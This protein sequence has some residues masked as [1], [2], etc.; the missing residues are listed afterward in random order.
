MPSSF[1]PQLSAKHEGYTM[2]YFTPADAATF[3]VGDFLVFDPATSRVNECGVDP[4]LILGLATV[5]AASKWLYNN[6]VT[7]A[8]M[9]PE[10]LVEL[11]GPTP[12]DSDL[13][14]DYGLTVDASGN[15]LLDR[16]KVLAAAVRVH[17]V[18]IDKTNSRFFVHF[19]AAN[20]QQDAIAS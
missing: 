14:K 5:P 15:W 11:G 2:R 9:T 19:L 10:L 16:A 13:G 1:K 6:Q 17:V 20:L 3:V 12:V 4:A 18:E 7:V 8:V